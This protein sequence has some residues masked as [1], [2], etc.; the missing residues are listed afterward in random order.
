[1]TTRTTHNHDNV[2]GWSRNP[3]TVHHCHTEKEKH[4]NSVL[5]VDEEG[6]VFKW[7]IKKPIKK[8]QSFFQGR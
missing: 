3:I 7:F 1:M 2:H 6:R 5:P 4:V 8:T